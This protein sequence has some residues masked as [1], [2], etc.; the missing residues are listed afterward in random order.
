MKTLIGTMSP[1]KCNLNCL[2]TRIYL[3][4]LFV[5]QTLPAASI[6]ELGNEVGRPVQR[7]LNRILATTNQT[8][9]LDWY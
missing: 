5:T 2:F 9:D 6:W 3:T 4:T 7:G 1:T 8:C